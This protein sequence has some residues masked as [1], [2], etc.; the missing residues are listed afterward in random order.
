MFSKAVTSKQ[1]WQLNFNYNFTKIKTHLVITFTFRVFNSH[2]WLVVT[3]LTS[4]QNSSVVTEFYWIVMVFI[5]DFKYL[6][7]HCGNDILSC[8]STTWTI[9]II[10]LDIFSLCDKFI[11]YPN[12]T[13]LLRHLTALLV[14]M[15]LKNLYIVVSS[16]VQVLSISIEWT[17]HEYSV[18]DISCQ[19]DIYMYIYIARSPENGSGL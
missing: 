1:T 8:S 4:I 2:K 7:Y 19:Q 11:S 10:F 9:L 6:D 15:S 12:M 3:M 13:L 5:I 14:T 16:H 17:S 18:M